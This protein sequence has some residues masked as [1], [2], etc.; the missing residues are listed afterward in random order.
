M[1]SQVML[2]K[3]V[4]ILLEK[5]QKDSLRVDYKFLENKL[6][7]CEVVSNQYLLDRVDSGLLQR[8]F[9]GESSCPKSFFSSNSNIFKKKK[10]LAL[11]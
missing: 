2:L 9:S 11:R 5:N 10:T 8:N 1:A 3:R 7:S 4:R 6:L